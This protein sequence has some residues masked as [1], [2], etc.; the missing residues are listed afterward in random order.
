[1]A[2]TS[3]LTLIQTERA[4]LDLKRHFEDTLTSSMRL[5]RVSAPM[6]VDAD[7]GLQDNL[8][9][10]ERPVAFVVPAIGKTRFE[11]VHSLAKWK[12]LALARYG[13][14]EGEGLY[15]D[16]NALRPDEPTISSSIHSVYVDQWDWERIM[17]PDQRN[18]DYLKAT[19]ETLY[20]AILA[21][22]HHICSRYDLKKFLPQRIHF[23]HSE[24]LLQRYPGMTAKERENAVCREFGA[25]FLIGIGGPL[26]DGKEHD[27]RA[28]DYDDWTTETAPGRKGLNGDILVFNPILDSAFELSSMGI[29]VSPEIL[30]QQLKARGCEERAQL[31]WHKMLLAGKLPQTIGGGI[32]Q[33]RLSMLLLQKRHIG[34]VQV[35]VWPADEITRCE[36]EG[37]Q[38][39]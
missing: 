25:V 36:A 38:I 16:M 30:T 13:I 26:Q 35:S 39:L 23:I 2:T 24:E 18:L 6:F 31:P 12:R 15:T 17:S 8:N 28:P 22:E 21:T 20:H 4:I 27:G 32:G 7:S 19:V 1:M 3:K 37:I 34:E 29:R 33:S 14:P 9:G 5:H 10:I 11:I